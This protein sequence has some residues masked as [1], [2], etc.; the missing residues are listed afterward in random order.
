MLSPSDIERI[1]S[2]PE[3]VQAP[4]TGCYVGTS[5]FTYSLG[6]P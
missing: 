3:P 6:W 1:E 4:P 2:T 5:C